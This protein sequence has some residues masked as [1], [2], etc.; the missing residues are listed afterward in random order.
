MKYSKLSRADLV[1]LLGIRDLSTTG[2]PSELIARLADNELSLFPSAYAKVDA[3]KAQ[4]HNTAASVELRGSKYADENDNGDTR[5][6]LPP[7]LWMMIFKYT[8]D[9]ELS[10][11]LFMSDIGI[12]RPAVWEQ[13]SA[14][15]TAILQDDLSQLKVLEIQGAFIYPIPKHVVDIVLRFE[16]IDIL[17]YIWK[18][19]PTTFQQDQI[20]L[21]AS[22]YNSPKVLE[23]WRQSM[24]EEELC[25][26][27]SCLDAASASGHT[28]ALDWWKASGLLL[29]IGKVMDFASDE[30]DV[31]VL[32]WWRTSGLKYKYSKFAMRHASQNGHINVLDWWLNSGLQ[33]FYD[34]G[35]LDYATRFNRVA[36]LEWW[37]W[38]GLMIE[39][40]IMDIE[41]ALGEA[42]VGGNECRN[43]WVEKGIDFGV[44]NSEWMRDRIL[45]E[46]AQ[47]RHA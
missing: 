29:K 19:R 6:R 7:E 23:W 11:A 47:Y 18:N 39:Y 28:G 43:W 10:A 9:W 1:F 27:E 3:L 24:P 21:L 35:C 40:R 16:Y 38:C 8:N 42:V 26:T 2:A 22:R 17:E 12:R 41:E 44:N 4:E 14:T 46:Q 37:F 5:V 20:P 25:Y 30:G 15:D 33:L 36:V 34:A 13:A 31:R 32:E 45:N